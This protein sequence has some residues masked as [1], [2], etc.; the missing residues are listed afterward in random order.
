MMLKLKR[1]YLAAMFV[2]IDSLYVDVFVRARIAK[3][4]CKGLAMIQHGPNTRNGD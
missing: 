2:S 3:K 4:M 1:T